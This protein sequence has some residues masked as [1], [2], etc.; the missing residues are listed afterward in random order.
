MH[1][2]F[3]WR[4]ASCGSTRERIVWV[5]ARAANPTTMTLWCDACAAKTEHERLISMPARYMGDRVRNPCVTGGSFDTMGFAPVQPLPDLPDG[6][7]ST[8]DNYKQLWSGKD[9]QEKRA[10]QREQNRKNREKRR[11]AAALQRGASVNMRVDRCAGDP[12]LEA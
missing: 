10:L 1:R 2:M 3:D 8:L 12:D 5:P 7:D 9:W 11:R 4:C 6:A